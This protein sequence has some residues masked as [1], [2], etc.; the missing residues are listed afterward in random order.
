MQLLSVHISAVE[1]FFSK[2]FRCMQFLRVLRF[3]RSLFFLEQFDVFVSRVYISVSNCFSQNS[4][5]VFFEH[6]VCHVSFRFP[7]A[8]RRALVR[9]S[10]VFSGISNLFVY[11]LF[12]CI[13]VLLTSVYSSPQHSPPV[14]NAPNEWG[15]G[16]S[17]RI[18]L[19]LVL[20][21]E[22]LGWRFRV[23][24]LGSLALEKLG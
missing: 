15:D 14:L 17:F 10:I 18:L 21:F 19:L 23:A 7:I 22:K 8:V 13:C 9:R 11:A 3:C 2:Q 5:D 16:F 1:L 24:I 12:R 6:R 20:M 4:F